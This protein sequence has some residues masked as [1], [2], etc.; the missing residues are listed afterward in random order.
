MKDFLAKKLKSFFAFVKPHKKSAI[1]FGGLV[2][3]GLFMLAVPSQAALDGES[4]AQWMLT[5][6][7][8]VMVWIT[9]FAIKLMIFF[10]QYFLA[11]AS[12]NSFV[13]SNVVMLGWT[14]VRDV[15]NMF[16]VVVLLAIAFGTI[17]GVEQY[18]WNKTLVKFILAAVFINF[19][20]LICGIF[21]DF[22]HVFTIT[23]VN[24]ISATAGGNLVKV[25]QVEKLSSLVLGNPD[26][27]SQNVDMAVRL[28]G[29]ALASM[30][31]ALMAAGVVAV[32]AF[33]LLA[34]MVALWILII[35]SPL[36]FVFQAIPQAQKYA[37][38]W[39]S[40]FFKYLTV[41]PIMVFFL[42]LT[43]A[44]AGSGTIAQDIGLYQ[45]MG[46][47]GEQETST[48]GNVNDSNPSAASLS[49]VTTWPAMASFFI[50]LGLLMVGVG[51][52]QK[53]G[54]V[55]AGAIQGAQ[56]FAKNVAT[57]AT[58]YAAGRWLVGGAKDKGK[59]LAVG[60]AKGTLK[61]GGYLVGA[62]KVKNWGK[63]Q[64]AGFH[65][66]RHDTG[67]RPVTEEYTDK[68]TGEKKLRYKKDDKGNLIMTKVDRGAAQKVAH[69]FTKRDIASEKKLD[70]TEK[71][72]ELRK[73]L[74][75]A[76]T[77]AIPTSLFKGAD[78]EIGDLDRIER[79]M[80]EQEK[81]RS[82]S[83]TQE[84]SAL[85]KQMVFANP[86]YKDGKFQ[87]DRP[88]I[89]EQTTNH[90]IRA[91]RAEQ[92]I[93]NV[94]S[95]IKIKIAQDA[96]EG[97]GPLA[98]LAKV[99]SIGKILEGTSESLENGV[100]SKE[101][102]K[103][104][105][106]GNSYSYIL[107]KL[108]QQ[109]KE[110]ESSSSEEDKAESLQLARLID[111]FKHG[112]KSAIKEVS[113]RFWSQEVRNNLAQKGKI[114]TELAT[115][116][117]VKKLEE[118]EQKKREGKLN[119][120]EEQQ[121]YQNV[122]SIVRSKRAKLKRIEEDLVNLGAGK[123]KIAGKDA[124]DEEKEIGFS[125]YDNREK[126]VQHLEEKIMK[127]SG[128]WSYGV[129][130]ALASEEEAT[131]NEG[132]KQLLADAE[133]SAIWDARGI[134][135]PSNVLNDRIKAAESEFNGMIY[136]QTVENMKNNMIEMVLARIDGREIDRGTRAA[137]TGLFMHAF[138]NSWLDDNIEPIA[139]DS[140]LGPI[141]KDVFGWKD[142]IY[143]PEK[144]NDLFTMISTGM[145]F[146][147]ARMQEP[148]S[149]MMD[150]AVVEL[151][152]STEDFFKGIKTGNFGVHQSALTDLEDDRGKVWERYEKSFGESP[153]EKETNY[154]IYKE[155]ITQD[156]LN[157]ANFEQY[158]NL[159]DK[160][161]LQT[162]HPEN[163]GH[164]QF[165]TMEDG[166]KY[167]VPVGV[168]Q[169][170]KYVAGDM[171]K[172][173]A[174]KRVNMYTHAIVDF[175][176]STGYVVRIREDDYRN[177]RGDINDP[178]VY[179]NTRKRAHNHMQARLAEQGAEDFLT[180]DGRLLFGKTKD[181]ELT[182]LKQFEKRTPEYK[183]YFEDIDTK[184]KARGLTVAQMKEEIMGKLVLK[185]IILPR[186]NTNLS[187]FMMS[188]ATDQKRKLHDVLATGDVNVEIAGLKEIG[189]IDELL[190]DLINGVV[191]TKDGRV[192]KIKDDDVLKDAHINVSRFTPSK[193]S[194]K[195]GEL[196]DDDEDVEEDASE[197]EDD[198]SEEG[199]NEE[200]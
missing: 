171:A 71:S 79:G 144:I 16:F 139:S 83:K 99:Q 179:K 57:I 26:M 78:E 182:L 35:L 90:E 140:V 63:R 138:N 151:G 175:D 17:L 145:D 100:F 81:A 178:T 51:V 132:H 56:N 82:E 49:A 101:N 24:A 200:T 32:Y 33:I 126:G 58:G 167:S 134:S 103:R 34:R 43:F 11:I 130:S 102:A 165:I 44:V 73:D 113:E 98:E 67:V 117:H 114:E 39:W 181:G 37:Q 177:V 161:L 9:E 131:Y 185:E 198:T 38:E 147:L 141:F 50:P 96:K 75:S 29:G 199:T 143:T 108:Q 170:K 66:W 15:A 136:D 25:F 27:D 149:A 46:N 97:K 94:Q 193:R 133:Q 6:I 89:G 148:I 186:L 106:E 157:Q 28:F 7:S 128:I 61:A 153:T 190:E 22:A 116:E 122:Q 107:A 36:A 18:Q 93:K 48:I 74:L 85:G 188:T 196:D 41:A 115:G 8:Y 109:Q 162:Q 42:W 65:D 21:I 77:G 152:M 31:F 104:M 86:R 169:A 64:V 191:R 129:T 13:D 69:F 180:D 124:S 92:A 156:K 91:K 70:K 154:S 87:E 47:S 166:Q 14:M 72:A 55:G 54:V 19:S 173:N 12:F 176:E 40:N 119:T 112:D 45:M 146:D 164:I 160:V 184:A 195:P 3:F 95:E 197:E 76:R 80:L 155:K 189:N 192:I 127:G 68:E 52:V 125:N 150:K 123:A 60:T 30:L 163:A 172:L 158:Q 187:D 10:L 121:E 142:T 23:F 5:E 111:K 59:R 2:L 118:L 88:T 135:T 20:N 1:I 62:G 4:M 110:K 174:Q 137:S 120:F 168:K 105:E 183:K 194:D 159:R 84:F 53:T